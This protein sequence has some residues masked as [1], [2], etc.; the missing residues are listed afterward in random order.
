[1]RVV[2]REVRVT[3]RSDAT[4]EG[5]EPL[6]RG[7]DADAGAGT[8]YPLQPEDCIELVNIG[9]WEPLLGGHNFRFQRSLVQDSPVPQVFF[10]F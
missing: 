4:P 6:G 7:G 3:R 8:T 2:P 10:F 9:L 1:M 5:G